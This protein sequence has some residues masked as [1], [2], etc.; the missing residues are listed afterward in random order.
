MFVLAHRISLGQF[1][2]PPGKEADQLLGDLQ[3]RL[4]SPAQSPASLDLDHPEH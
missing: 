3:T 1:I 4:H 2:V